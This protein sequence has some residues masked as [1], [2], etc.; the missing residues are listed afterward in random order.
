[1]EQ[2]QL[3]STSSGLRLFTSLNTAITI[4]HDPSA[5]DGA[6]WFDIDP[7]AQGIS[8]Q[9]YLAVAGTYL[10]Y[11]SILRGNNGTIVLDFS[12]TS[13]TMNPSTGY[14]FTTSTSSPFSPVRTTGVGL[15]PHQSF[16]DILF[17]EPR[18][19]DYSAAALDP[20]G[21]DIWVADEY[22]P[23]APAGLDLIDN[24]GTRV[25]QVRG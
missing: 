7:L 9:G 3:V 2:V 1:M 13:P 11:P 4:G 8:R 20:N 17:N 12:M 18:W 6:A 21:H 14:A 23:P 25:W 22:I 24:W 10:L 16:S 15:G 5:R 19:G